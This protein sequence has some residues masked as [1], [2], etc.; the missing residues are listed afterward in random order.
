[1]LA[2]YAID[3]IKEKIKVGYKHSFHHSFC[4]FSVS[5]NDIC[6][7]NNILIKPQT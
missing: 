3:S 6:K 7:Y 2:L 5:L 4:L 1:M